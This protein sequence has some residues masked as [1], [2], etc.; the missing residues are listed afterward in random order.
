MTSAEAAKTAM[1][2]GSEPI[3][4]HLGASGSEAGCSA[5]QAGQLLLQLLDLLTGLV[6]LLA[7]V[8]AELLGLLLGGLLDRLGRGRDLLVDDLLDLVAAGGVLERRGGLRQLLVGGRQ[9]LLQ[10]GLVAEGLLGVLLQRG[11]LGL[12]VVEL[13]RHVGRRILRRRLGRG[14]EVADQR[15]GPLGQRGGLRSR[16]A[17]GGGRGALGGGGGG[18]RLRGRRAGGVLVVVVV[19]A[20]AGGEQR[21]EGE[22]D[23][24]QS[25]DT[26]ALPGLA[27]GETRMS[28]R[29]HGRG[30]VQGVR[31]ILNVIWFVFAGLWLA[32]GY[33]FAALICFI[34]IIT[35]PF[36]VAALRIAIFALWPFGKTVVQRGDAGVASAIGNVLW[37]ILCGWWLVL[38]HLV[39]GVALCLT[40]IGIPLGLANFKL[41]PV[42]LLPLGREIVDVDDARAFGVQ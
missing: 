29:G 11:R 21:R 33:A 15:D 35:I 18:R 40:I 41:I 2:T 25:C 42:T 38:L 16:R 31:L 19:A 32:L 20:A 10:L 27:A 3:A 34:L 23:G 12:H 6:E 30:T 28:A 17:A 13:L 8:A 1:L 24:E 9:R 22:K 39:S 37:I 36:G 4:A 7:D 5:T 26:S 14:C